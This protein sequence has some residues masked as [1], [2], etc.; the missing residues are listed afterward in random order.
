MYKPVSERAIIRAED[1]DFWYEE[2]PPV[3]RTVSLSVDPGEWIALIGQNGSG[4]TTLVKHFN[5]LLRPKR[6]RVLLAGQ[7][8]AKQSIGTLARRVG[9]VFQ[10]PDHQIFSATVT[11]EIA[12]GLRALG[13]SPAE[14]KARTEDT[15]KAFDLSK[16]AD[17]PPA[18]LG[19]GL[20][21]R[22]TV[23]AVWAMQPDVVILDE[24]TTGLDRHH[25]L[26]LMSRAA[27]LHEQGHTII[28]IT[29][30]M[31]LVAEYAQRVVIM[32]AGEI[33]ADGSARFVFQ[34][35]EL[36]ARVSLAPPPITML[37]QRLAPCGLASDLLTI[38]EFE[39]EYQKARA[40][41]RQIASS[42]R[43]PRES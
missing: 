4:K 13:F 22:I 20:R 31:R 18:I 39:T 41:R 10:S 14:V 32:H 35:A 17:A 21:R 28:M 19:Y 23:A 16:F 2:G 36:L 11:E 37:S 25:T 6:G 27:D 1:V 5:G 7:D 38:D 29:H 30:D 26:E 3:L 34:Q 15:L 24:P 8:T 42:A 9:Y 12:F 43:Y 40:R 33:V